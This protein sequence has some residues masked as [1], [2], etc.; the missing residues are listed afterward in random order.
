MEPKR[1]VRHDVLWDDTT[2]GPGGE[3]I[4]EYLPQISKQL[5]VRRGPKQNMVFCL[6]WRLSHGTGQLALDHDPLELS[7]KATNSKVQKIL[8]EKNEKSV[9]HSLSP[10][11]HVAVKKKTRTLLRVYAMSHPRNTSR[12]PCSNAS[13]GPCRHARLVALP[14]DE[15]RWPSSPCCAN[16]QPREGHGGY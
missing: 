14:G 9:L 2:A 13:V 11:L 8:P 16:T 3:C 5:V 12:P 6:S 4:W 15:L 1:E 10:F 7:L